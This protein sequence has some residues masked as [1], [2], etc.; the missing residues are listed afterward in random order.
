L[1]TKSKIEKTLDTL[2]TAQNAEKIKKIISELK[3][4]HDTELEISKDIQNIKFWVHLGQ[5]SSMS[6][7]LMKK[8]QIGFSFNPSERE[9]K[10]WVKDGFPKLSHLLTSL[11]KKYKNSDNFELILFR[12]NDGEPFYF[13]Q[14]EK[15]TNVYVNIDTYLEYGTAINDVIYKLKIVKYA[16]Q[17]TRE[18]SAKVPSA[19][20]TKRPT[21]ELPDKLKSSHYAVIEEIINDVENMPESEEK[22]NLTKII[23]QSNIARKSFEEF[24]K[25]SPESASKKLHEFTPALDKLTSKEVEILLN[26]ILNS[27]I[28][29]DFINS[30]AKLPKEHRNK[31][32]QHLPEMTLMF[33]KHEKL[34]KSLKE[35]KKLIREHSNS[36]K[37]DEA[38]IHQ[39]L[40]NDYWL[41]GIEYFDKELLSDI[42]SEKHRTQDTKLAQSRK[43]PDFIIKRLAT[44]PNTL[45]YIR[46]DAK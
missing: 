32:A 19:F 17:I 7:K 24:N 29:V 13:Q 3:D 34:K 5:E 40:I 21:S 43:R 14:N 23:I 11:E 41:L 45:Q 35:F 44:H 15:A 18:Y 27:R 8:K 16:K 2:P 28:S 6:T 4:K 46:I 12:S 9:K 39:F 20:F 10:K 30:V 22:T 31:I 25:M 36:S 26:K 38:E 42:D 1:S 33:A 37:K